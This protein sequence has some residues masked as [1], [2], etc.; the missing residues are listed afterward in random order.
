M[1]PCRICRGDGHIGKCRVI[2]SVCEGT[3]K[4]P[5]GILN[6]EDISAQLFSNLPLKVIR[7]VGIESQEYDF[8]TGK[9]TT[10]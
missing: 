5:G 4:V 9:W 3:G 2:C 6:P 7:M 8:A 10:K 1:K